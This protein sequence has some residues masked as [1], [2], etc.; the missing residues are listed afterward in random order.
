MDSTGDAWIPRLEYDALVDRGETHP[1]EGVIPWSKHDYKKAQQLGRVSARRLAENI[2]NMSQT[3]RSHKMK[4]LSQMHVSL[5]SGASYET[6]RTQGG[7]WDIMSNMD[8]H[9]GEFTLFMKCPV[10]SIFEQREDGHYDLYGKFVAA[11]E[12]ESTEVWKIA[13]LTEPIDMDYGQAIKPYFSDTAGFCAGLDSRLGY[14]LFIWSAMWFRDL[15]KGLVPGDMDTY[16]KAKVSVITEPGGKIRPVSAGET[17]MALFMA[18]A[19]HILKELLESIPACRVGLT[20]S[21]N[22]WRFSEEIKHHENWH[23]Y[24]S[25]SDLTAATDRASTVSV[26]AC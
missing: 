16:P 23:D 10:G 21:A 24:I 5:C 4:N 9:E 8:D 14:L 2:Q 7:K 26:M 25:T 12:H 22:L 13:Y 20:D 17:Q 19:G 6:P 15:R 18:P 3:S 11:R 1:P